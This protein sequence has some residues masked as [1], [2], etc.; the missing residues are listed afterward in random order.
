MNAEAR[1][2]SSALD[3]TITREMRYRQALARTAWARARTEFE[4][5]EAANDAAMNDAVLPRGAKADAVRDAVR[6]DPA[7]ANAVR[8]ARVVNAVVLGVAG[9]LLALAAL[10]A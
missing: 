3:R 4:H 2:F 1:A 9:L 6:G 5:P 10:I 7:S 8:T